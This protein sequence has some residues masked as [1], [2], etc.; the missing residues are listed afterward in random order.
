[1]IKYF[2]NYYYGSDLFLT[3]L[4]HAITSVWG[5][6][7]VSAMIRADTRFKR[8]LCFVLID[9]RCF[10]VPQVEDHCSISLQDLML[11]TILLKYILTLQNICSKF[12]ISLCSEN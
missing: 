12:L 3:C 10:R 1:M 8:F 2:I 4:W 6:I 11:S 5:Q 9:V 7:L